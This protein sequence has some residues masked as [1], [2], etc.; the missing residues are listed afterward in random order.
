MI[1]L[2]T[3]LYSSFIIFF[4][5]CSRHNIPHKDVA[6]TKDIIIQQNK[7]RIF[8]LDVDSFVKEVDESELKKQIEIDLKQLGYRVTLNKALSSTQLSIEVE[9]L[10]RLYTARNNDFSLYN[11]GIFF[12]LFLQGNK[13]IDVNKIKKYTGKIPI[14]ILRTSIKILENSSEQKTKIIVEVIGKKKKI[15]VEALQ[16]IR[17]K[18]SKAISTIFK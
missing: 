9:E 4:I 17:E 15:E 14:H 2:K 5:S 1:Y 18:L 3:I 13:N 8:F 16:K 10:N 7:K 11:T 6:M 12:F